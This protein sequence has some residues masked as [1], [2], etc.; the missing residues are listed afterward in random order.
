[1]QN[2]SVEPF[3]RTSQN[4]QE[5]PITTSEEP[6]NNNSSFISNSSHKGMVLDLCKMGFDLE[7]IELCICFFRINSIDQIINLLTKEEGVWQHEYIEGENKNCVICKE[8]SD[9]TNMKVNRERNSLN[10]LISIKNSNVNIDINRL[11]KITVKSEYNSHSSKEISILVRNK[12]EN[13]DTI[14]CQVCCCEVNVSSCF[15]HTCGHFFCN[16][17]WVYFLDE[18]ISKSDVI[19]INCM[20]K[21]CQNIL[22]EEDIQKLLKNETELLIKY[23]KFKFN[24]LIATSDDKKFCPEINCG[25]Y[26][27]KHLEKF[28]TCNKGHQFCFDCL[29]KWHGKKKCEDLIDKDFEKWKKGKLIKQCPSCKFWTEKNDGCNHMTCRGCTYQWCWLCEGRYT[30]NHY[31]N[32]GVCNGLQFSKK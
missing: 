6:Q 24:K 18:K 27:Q 30:S 16:E 8:Y 20:M 32:L 31:S 3:L 13:I 17:C 25:G 12:N 1:M 4:K 5:T 10:N 2:I 19:K 22:S 26:A 11:S 9:H 15:S 14:E 29:K 7:M 28:V 21:G 23:E